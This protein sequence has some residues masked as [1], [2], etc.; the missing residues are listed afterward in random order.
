MAEPIEDAWNIINKL[1]IGRSVNDPLWLDAARW[2]A[3]NRPPI[4]SVVLIAQ[5]QNQ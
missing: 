3:K 2:L 1:L 4:K 5:T